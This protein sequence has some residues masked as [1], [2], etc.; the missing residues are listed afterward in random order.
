MKKR[1]WIM[2]EI[3]PYSPVGDGKDNKKYI[4]KMQQR[5][6]P[7][8]KCSVRSDA[9]HCCSNVQTGADGAEEESPPLEL[10]SEKEQEL[11]MVV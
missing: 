7:F 10:V 8:R 2:K 1:A 5:K 6:S 11:F 3:G 9:S 4:Q